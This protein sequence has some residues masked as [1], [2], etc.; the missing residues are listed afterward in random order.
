M[1][2]VESG[3]RHVAWD[4]MTEE[5]SGNQRESEVGAAVLESWYRAEG[6]YRVCEEDSGVH[7]PVGA[8]ALERAAFTPSPLEL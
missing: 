3:S 6:A 8:G 7:C 1:L 5:P 4:L 2:R